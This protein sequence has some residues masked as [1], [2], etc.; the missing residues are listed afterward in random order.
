MRIAKGVEVLELKE[1]QG[2]LHPTLIWDEDEVIL[3][4]YENWQEFRIIGRI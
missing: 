3:V 1:N 2:N 4:D